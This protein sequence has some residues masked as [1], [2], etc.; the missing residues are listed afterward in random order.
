MLLKKTAFINDLF[1]QPDGRILTVGTPE[2]FNGLLI[3][4]YVQ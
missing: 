4:V 2:G 3:I 1:N